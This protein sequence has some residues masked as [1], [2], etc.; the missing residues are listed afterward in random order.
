[1]NKSKVVITDE[2]IEA[3]LEEAK[4]RPG[5]LSAVSA[6]YNRA[7]DLIIIHLDNGT[8]LVVQRENLQGLEKATPEQL[9]KVEA[10]FGSDIGWWDIDVH[11]HLSS[12]L[13]GRYG[14][15]K[16]MESLGKHAVAA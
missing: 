1:M 5:Y 2:D 10:R 13:E 11:H 14:S 12:L 16:W 15:K 3:A 7:L 6:E 4:T 9:A 8:R